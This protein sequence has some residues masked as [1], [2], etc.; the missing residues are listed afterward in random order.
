M[1]MK[2]LFFRA[3]PTRTLAERK[4]R[5][6]GGK[7]AKERI[8]VFMCGDMMGDLEK[9]LAFEKTAS[10]RSFKGLDRDSLTV[11]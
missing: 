9:L 6:V 8:S 5:C 11:Q 1:V 3:I 10:P 7:K 4:E 2:R